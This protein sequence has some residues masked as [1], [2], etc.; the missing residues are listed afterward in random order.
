MIKKIMYL[1]FLLVLAAAIG[2][3]VYRYLEYKKYEPLREDQERIATEDYTAVFFSTFPIDNYT[4]DD[5][6]YYRDI[7]PLKAA[8]CIPDMETLNDYFI[9]VSESW[10]EVSTVYLGVRPD[11]VTAE[12]LMTLMDT[13]PDKR[14]EVILAYPS[15][16]YWRGLDEEKY[17]VMLEAYTD[18][19]NNLIPRYEDS[20]WLQANLSV[21]FYGS[22]E[23]LVGNAYNY[24]N[25]FNVNAG[26]S[27][28]LSM[29]SDHDHGYRLTLENYQDFLEDFETLV[30]DC[31]EEESE[32]PS[33]S[34]W[35]VV[36]F[37]DSI[38][39]FSETSSIPGAV[40][41]ITGA[42]TYNCGQGGSHAAVQ[43]E[44]F[45]GIPD[46]VDIF[47]AKNADSF[48]ADSQIY[49][50]MT[51]YFEHSKK[52]RQKCFVLNFGMNDYYNG[53]P[54]R[55][56]DPYDCA[57][58]IGALRTAVDKLQAAYP[59]AVIILMTPNFTSYFGNGLEPQSEVGGLLPDYAGAVSSLCD[60]KGLL[61]YNSYSELD[62]NS[63]N[64]TEY[65]L[66]G[67]HPNEATR[68]VMA[69]GVAELL[70]SAA[71]ANTK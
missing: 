53:Y 23:W 17:P 32:H 5:F 26:I 1:V 71:E 31:R 69:Q 41:G 58:Y 65:L 42:H 59:D 16:D 38:I 34:K 52:R 14:Y 55:T 13:W 39:A 70:W 24:E 29:F 46:V 36:F 15:L 9:R 54:V 51:D 43:G 50:G 48:D 7:Y 18:F 47:L 21:Y 28:T 37:G 11:I 10:N 3:G 44:G 60:E 20:E 12:D 49:A 8:Y 66:D 64:H 30:A 19:I 61:C 45:P 6:I 22:T 35:D 68:Y 25:A 33:L 62:I 40:G 2:F 4:E 56:E 27:H 67:C 57:S 63:T